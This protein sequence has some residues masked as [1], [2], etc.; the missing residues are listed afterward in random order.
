[1]T[2]RERVLAAFLL[3]VIILGGGGL[4]VQMAFLGP[5]RQ[6]NGEIAGLDE[7]NRKK[8]EELKTIEAANE[9]AKRLSPRLSQWKQLSLPAPKEMQ[10]EEVMLHL[11][12]KQ[13]DYEQ[14]LYELLHRNGFSP[15]SISVSARPLEAP[16]TGPTAAKGPPPI[17]R[18]LT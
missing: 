16:K 1:M 4:L 12:S 5:L 7:E 3:A 17:F 10:P 18:A 13:V 2:Q 15:G 14:Y 6:L 8:Q 11:K 9:R